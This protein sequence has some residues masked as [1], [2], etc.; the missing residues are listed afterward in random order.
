MDDYQIIA[1]FSFFFIKLQTRPACIYLFVN[2]TCNVLL[3]IV[4]NTNTH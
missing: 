3:H 2:E 1:Y 4:E